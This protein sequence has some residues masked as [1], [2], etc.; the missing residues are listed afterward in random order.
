MISDWIR[1]LLGDEGILQM[2]KCIVICV[3]S[4]LNQCICPFL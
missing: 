2:I 1:S 4:S 3:G